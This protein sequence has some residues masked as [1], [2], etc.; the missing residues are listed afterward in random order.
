MKAAKLFGKKDLRIVDVPVPEIAADEM[1]VRVRAATVCGTDLRMYANGAAG[2]SEETPLTLCHEFAGTIEKLGA[3]VRGYEEGRRVSVA[4]NIGCGICDLCIS[5]NSHH[6][7]KL[8]ALGI[9]MDGGFAEYVRVPALAIAHGNVTPLADNV[10]FEA[11]AAS[12]AFACVYN[13]FERYGVK[14]GDI[15]LIIGAGAIG[16]M[17]AKLAFMSGASCVIMSD[18]SEERLRLCKSLD[19][20]ITVAIKDPVAKN[21]AEKDSAAKDAVGKNYAAK[22]FAETVGRATGGLGADVVVTAC[23]VQAV[24][25]EAFD[26]AGLNARVNFFGGLPAGTNAVL[27]TNQI[28]YKQ[29]IVSGTTRS[30]LEQYRKAIGFIEK[31]IVDIDPLVTD[32][33]PLE[34]IQTAFEN[35]ASQKG[36]K[37][38]IVF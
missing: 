26:Y 38:A 29:L 23:G 11:A 2:V 13:S 20:R 6:C 1:L 36:M 31:G 32:R 21:P 25:E 33:Y 5:G 9:H 15:V 34:E 19:P 28:H 16:M 4:P 3:D 24:Q 18:L 10:S 12:E 37:H 30:N 17:H 35:A 22:D 8:I 27:D 7:K 14:P